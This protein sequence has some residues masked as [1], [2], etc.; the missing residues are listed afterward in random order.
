MNKQT[1]VMPGVARIVL[2]ASLLTL[3]AC[4]GGGGGEPTAT[5][6]PV[7]TP[8]PAITGVAAKGLLV[9]ATVEL[10][11][12]NQFGFTDDST[13]LATTETD[14]NGQFTLQQRPIAGP[15]LVITRGGTYI[16]ES[17][18]EPNPA[19]KRQITLSL[20]QGFEAVL[21]AGQNSLAVTPFSQMV[22][23]RARVENGE[24]NRFDDFLTA[25][26]TRAIEVFG[27][28]PV[29]NLP[30]DPI[31]P[32]STASAASREYAM[33]LGGFA[34][35]VNATAITLGLQPNFPVIDALLLDLADGRFDTQN[36]G[37]QISVDTPAGPQNLPQFDFN[38]QIERFRNN[39]F[40]QYQNTTLVT[41]DE[42]ALADDIIPPE[43]D[44]RAPVASNDALTI[45]ED[46]SAFVN[47]LNGDVDPDGDT[48]TVI[49]V[50]QPNQGGTTAV[51]TDNFVAYVPAPNFFGTETFTYTISDGNGET[52]TGL[53][54]ITVNSVNDLPVAVPDA[55]Q[56]QEDV[57]LIVDTSE[58]VL[59]NDTDVDDEALQAVQGQL[60][61]P[62]G[63][64]TLASDGGFTFTPTQDFTG[65]AVFNYSAFDGEDP[66]ATTSITI[67]VIGE[68]DD[69]VALDDSFQN[70]QED[71]SE[72][73][74][75]V[76]ANDSD[77]DSS[78]ASL[79][80]AAVNDYAGDGT[81]ALAENG[82][83]LLYTPAENFNGTET[84]TYT[85][86]DGDGGQDTATVT[87]QV[88]PVNDPPTANDDLFNGEFATEEGGALN[89]DAPGVLGNDSDIDGDIITVDT[90]PVS[91]PSNG[92]LTLNADGSFSYAHDG[93]ETAQ[94]S[95]VYRILDRNQG[96]AEATVT[97][98][99]DPVN[100]APVIVIND[101]L[102]VDEGDSGFITGFNSG[103]L[104][105]EDDDHDSTELTYTL[106]SVPSDGT[107]TLLGN[108]LEVNGSFT[109]EDLDE[110]GIE[111]QHNGA[112]SSFDFFEFQVVDAEG[113]PATPDLRSPGNQTKTGNSQQATS[114]QFGF[115]HFFDINI[116]PVEDPPVVSVNNGIDVPN[117]SSSVLTTTDLSASD[118]DSS[119]DQIIFTV[120]S[121]SACGDFIVNLSPV[122]SFTQADIVAGNVELL[123]TSCAD[124][125]VEPAQLEVKNA[126]ETPTAFS[127]D[128][129]V[130]GPTI[131]TVDPVQ[132]AAAAPARANLQITASDNLNFGTVTSTSVVIRGS[133]SGAEFTRNLPTGTGNVIQSQIAD[134]LAEQFPNELINVT[135]TDSILDE[136]GGA[137]APFVYNFRTAASGTGVGTYTE[138]SEASFVFE[139]TLAIAAADM[140]GDGDVDIVTSHPDS[141][142]GEHFH[143]DLND[144]SGN[145]SPLS[146]I[147]GLFPALHLADLDLDGDIDVVLLEDVE[148]ARSLVF[149][150]NDGS[151]NLSEVPA[152]AIDVDDATT[153]F[154]LGDLDGNGAPD[155]LT[156]INGQELRSQVFL[157]VTPGSIGFQS[158]PV[159]NGPSTGTTTLVPSVQIA[160][161]D[162]DGDLDG[163]VQVDSGG[164]FIEVLRN[165]GTGQL[166]AEIGPSVFGS[167]LDVADF[168]GDD[169]V[170]LL[171]AGGGSDAGFIFFGGGDGTF[172]NGFS[173][174]GVSVAGMESVVGDIDADGD[175]DVLTVFPD[176]SGSPRGD[177]TYLNDGSGNFTF[178]SVINGDRSGINAVLIDADG[179]RDLDIYV[180]NQANP[181]QSTPRDRVFLNNNAP[182]AVDDG[183]FTI[184]EDSTSNEV[185]LVSNDT[186]PDGDALQI[187]QVAGEESGATV[188]IV[189]GGQSINYAPP[190]NFDASDTLTYTI[191]DGNGGT[192]TANVIFNVTPSNDRPTGANQTFDVDENT[193]NGTVVGTFV[194]D[195][196]DGDTLQY[197]I[198]A[199][200]NPGGAFAIDDPTSGV[201]TV[202]NQSELDFE[203][204]PQFQLTVEVSDGSLSTTAVAV[205]NINDVNEPPSA[206]GGNI[207]TTDEDTPDS[208]GAGSV[209]VNDEDED[210]DLT[211]IVSVEGNT[212]NVGVQ[213]TL[214]SGALLTV[215]ADG[216]YSYDPNG[217][218]ES[219]GD[220]DIVQDTF[221]YTISDGEFTS[222]S[223]A[224][225]TVTGV[226]D[227]P[228]DP[229][230]NTFAVDYLAESPISNSELTTD[231]VD[232]STAA[233]I[234]YRIIDA[235]AAGTLR[236][237]A[238]PPGTTLGAAGT[239]SQADIDNLEVVYENT[240]RPASNEQD[241][242][243]FE[244]TNT[245][246][247]EAPSGPFTFVIDVTPPANQ[248]PSV[249]V[250]QRRAE[251]DNT[252][253]I[254]NIFID[255]ADAASPYANTDYSVTLEL[256]R[257]TVPTQFPGDIFVNDSN[258]NLTVT[259]NTTD[260]VTVS[261]PL[262]DIQQVFASGIF[263][264]PAPTTTLGYNL[265]VTID[266]QDPRDS[267]SGPGSAALQTSSTG[268]IN[269]AV[270][271]Q[272][273]PNAAVFG[274][275]NTGES[276][277]SEA[278]GIGD[279]NGDGFDDIAIVTSLAG[280]TTVAIYFGGE[281][282]FDPTSTSNEVVS[283]DLGSQVELAHA[284]FNRDGFADL[285][286]GDPEFDLPGIGE[287]PGI[288]DGGRVVLL[289]G[290]ATN[291]GSIDIS[292]VDSV[293]G[294][295]EIIPGPGF[296][297]GDRFGAQVAAGFFDDDGFPDIAV[298]I[299]GAENFEV[300]LAN[301]GAVVIF[302]ANETVGDPDADKPDNDKS[303]SFIFG[304]NSSDQLGNVL[305]MGDVNRDGYDDLLLGAPNASRN[306]ASQNGLAVVVHGRPNDDRLPDF[307]GVTDAIAGDQG[308]E[309][310]GETGSG[311]LGASID[312]IGD[313]DGDRIGD[314]IVGEPGFT[315]ASPN[316][317]GL[318][319]IVFGLFPGVT[320]NTAP[321]DFSTTG[322]G[323][324][325][326]GDFN[327]GLGF[328]DTVSGV[329]D[330]NGDGL[331][332]VI[333]GHPRFEFDDG[334]GPLFDGRAYLIYGVSRSVNLFGSS[335]FNNVLGA[336][337]GTV[338]ELKGQQ[339]PSQDRRLGATVA[340]SGDFDGDGFDDLLVAAP[341]EPSTQGAG[342]NGLVF[343][344]RG[345]DYTVEVTEQGFFGDDILTGV[346][347]QNI[348]VGGIGNDVIGGF[349]I[350]DVLLGGSGDDL[351]SFSANV[352][353]IDGDTG[354]DGLS[355]PDA[356]TIV[357]S[358]TAMSTSFTRNTGYQLSLR[359]IEY[360]V[361]GA[362]SDLEV[363]GLS[364]RGI[365][366][367]DNVIRIDSDGTGPDSNNL[368][369]TDAWLLG[370][371]QTI[372]VDGSDRLYQ[373]YTNRGVRMLVDVDIN[374]EQIPL[375][376]NARLVSIVDQDQFFGQNDADSTRPAISGNGQFAV[377]DSASTVPDDFGTAPSAQAPQPTNVYRK[378]L[379][380]GAL[381][382][383]STD[384]GGGTGNGDS[385]HACVSHSGNLVAFRTAATNLPTI[386]P[387]DPQE[388]IDLDP[389]ADGNGEAQLVLADLNAGTLEVV[390]STDGETFIPFDSVGSDCVFSADDG[391]LFFLGQSNNFQAPSSNDLHVWRRSLV[392]RGQ[393]PVPVS[394]DVDN[395]FSYCDSD[396]VT[397]FG[398]AGIAPSAD[399][400]LVAFAA[401]ADLPNGT[402]SNPLSAGS[403]YDI[404]L[405]DM[406][407]DSF[408]VPANG[409]AGTT[410]GR[411]SLSGDGN[412]LVF[413]S[414]GDFL[415]DNTGTSDVNIY[416]LER[417][418]G[419][420]TRV[421][422]P[423][424]GSAFGNSGNGSS[425]QDADGRGDP[426]ISTNGRTI[427]FT[428]SE[429][430]DG[431][432]APIGGVFVYL[433]QV[434]AN[435]P[436]SN[437]G[438]P[439][440]PFRAFRNTDGQ[441]FSVDGSSPA[442]AAFASIDF[443]G[444]GIVF[445]DIA[446]NIVSNDEN[447]VVDVFAFENP[448]FE[449]DLVADLDGDS[450]PDAAEIAS[451]NTNPA[452][453]DTD[454]DNLS[455]GVE[456]GF[457][458]DVA[459]YT[460]GTDTDPTNSDTDGDDVG[461]GL[462]FELT[463]SELSSVDGN[464]VVQTI[465]FVTENAVGG[466]T[467]ATYEDA[468]T[469]D[470][471]YAI[472]DNGVAGNPV[473][474]MIQSG[475]HQSI[476]GLTMTS[477]ANRAYV[478]GVGPGVPYPVEPFA[479]F[480]T[481]DLQ[482]PARGVAIDSSSN[483]TIRNLTLGN[484]SVENGSGGG[485][486]VDNLSTSIVLQSVFIQG[487][488]ATKSSV[489]AGVVG[490]G[491]LAVLASSNVL[492]LDSEVRF[493]SVAESSGST[494]Y[495][496]G[497]LVSGNGSRIILV[498]S[499][500]VGN[501]L[502]ADSGEGLRLGAGLAVINNAQAILDDSGVRDHFFSADEGGGVYVSSSN[503]TLDGSDVSNNQIDGTTGAGMALV[504]VGTVNINASK[505]SNNSIVGLTDN[506]LRGGGIAVIASGTVN[507][508]DSRIVGN[509]LFGSG[510]LP[511]VRGGGIYTGTANAI[512]LNVSNSVIADNV[513]SSDVNSGAGGGIYTTAA[514]D[515]SITDSTI[516]SNAAAVSGGGLWINDG[517]GI[518]SHRIVNNLFTGN[519]AEN[520]AGAWGFY[521]NTSGSAA[522]IQNNTFAYNQSTVVE[523][524][525]GDGGGGLNITPA[526]DGSQ[527]RILDNILVANDD[528]DIVNA[529]PEQ[530][531]VGPVATGLGVEIEFNLV[532]SQAIGDGAFDTTLDPLWL[533]GFYLDQSSNPLVGLGGTGAGLG[534]DTTRT[535]A[536][537]GHSG[538]SP[539]SLTLNATTSVAGTADGGTNQN[540]DNLDIGF[541]ALSAS[542]G[543]VSNVAVVEPAN[544]TL[545]CNN[546]ELVLRE[547]GGG[548]FLIPVTIAG[549]SA[550]NE[551][552]PNLIFGVRP[553]SFSGGTPTLQSRTT[554][555]PLGSTDSVLPLHGG[556]DDHAV[557]F[558][559]DNTNLS[560]GETIG[561]TF[562][563]LTSGATENVV[564]D[565]AC[566]S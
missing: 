217:A 254:T 419:V 486:L 36:F 12:L 338:V 123:D 81:I 397:T 344:N 351:I 124:G 460:P 84:F 233:D 560:D 71:T 239:F 295:L 468:L 184:A 386:N 50:S 111:Y 187:T 463:G 211:S 21:P 404:V 11:T 236:L 104:L 142:F 86:S 15:L 504:S 492:M 197:S 402:D 166:T 432:L 355:L 445:A 543:T 224:F 17:D 353:R 171:I 75:D 393:N 218:F 438:L 202:G 359:D 296:D 347:A 90:T 260:A 200:T 383:L 242:F 189:G 454:G 514:G 251:V 529:D 57:P 125:D 248:A 303:P 24:S 534:G 466:G 325:F 431:Q 563:E 441:V 134:S 190:P 112:E 63:T 44:N 110:A 135:L 226:D 555:D 443:T 7:V 154:A 327:I 115:S 46:E 54:T 556:R 186:D 26:R 398:C 76:L 427:V 448:L 61:S 102:T 32:S 489:E 354:F 126:G 51:Q 425:S 66:S 161:I 406:T 235:P 94:D 389:Q 287:M 19:L 395:D 2:S 144:G 225:E 317:T 27:F 215:N 117:N 408:E 439:G 20:D 293:P 120:V 275:Q 259:G 421:N 152:A 506:N 22:L 346:A 334:Q 339:A 536:D 105:T 311:F 414:D 212:S 372:N 562:V 145:F 541:H 559:L 274:A 453:I 440:A 433:K 267:G 522:L 540:Q 437:G 34:N 100:D 121:Q 138:L 194:A 204:T 312:F 322:N 93:S 357:L 297:N 530:D 163:L 69:P 546:A 280:E 493:N 511:S 180:A 326:E 467:G 273:A 363:D 132:N 561:L 130:N 318:A 285:I 512:R 31:A 52:A 198:V 222:S 5:A 185:N 428:S 159:V 332:D 30:A 501:D 99:I 74:L 107:L 451:L 394:Y 509:T 191:E 548:S 286:I 174:F 523:M 374:R 268:E 82:T 131:V 261:G 85:V 330:F 382:I 253:I 59:I 41:I 10:F 449:E 390:S 309:F 305:A 216:S 510:S 229:T 269:V 348:V 183:P 329:G 526:G 484:G 352:L 505:I 288:T 488:Q 473:I 162:N 524:G 479:T 283:G 342:G 205:I 179:D 435:L 6:D 358:A 219:L 474:F 410:S 234:V 533:D 263:V 377:F 399:G 436:T 108:V 462:E 336:P 384:G 478:G 503:L 177:V 310:V 333:I 157:N 500:V 220:S 376:T 356:T 240:A 392:N 415:F 170:D 328:G 518:V 230:I 319:H 266:D 499:Q 98:V 169:I 58:G 13:P 68:N 373:A 175:L 458:G 430:L 422:A 45:N 33:A 418:S 379:S 477:A 487:N 148:G 446:N 314:W 565:Y 308:Y 4:G 165:D 335:S 249:F 262:L 417:S 40:S 282:V 23:E 291:Q 258:P 173:Q 520:G 304:D 307:G 55:Y 42:I 228:N 37:S 119:D 400:N 521:N 25:T 502:V 553:F 528:A 178:G 72:N 164:E 362:G 321:S 257:P 14:A 49:A 241:S 97:L 147:D 371:Q 65:D 491:G 494:I 227:A 545:D 109:Q 67:G 442:Q 207:G 465:Y 137:L 496:G 469:I 158:K 367:S 364:L 538:L 515:V 320:P 378:D 141:G 172:N 470:E 532:A 247:D 113:A 116:N 537:L 337:A 471:A 201:I 88:Q 483:I 507:V 133:Q 155:I 206:F 455:D 182:T 101:G 8:P 550:A 151:A 243:T 192:A 39:N 129:R 369:A 316:G 199:N 289:F 127:F 237:G 323:Y 62:G 366:G 519:V 527:V 214:A 43:P 551:S 3:A 452:N 368:V 80:I 564:F 106:L 539:N 380:T 481:Q 95:F 272:P 188:T 475:F 223:T 91:G 277:G 78:Q 9:G 434:P 413:E 391:F 118:P 396:G 385:A 195:D 53:V 210:G 542:V 60:S 231:D 114:G 340:P 485:I 270:L 35:M 472:S 341:D 447:G 70:I 547:N 482:S 209:G 244:L 370:G 544:L 47:V 405:R 153:E 324:T 140:D 232:T 279:R 424:N 429:T 301:Q 459:T 361:M 456:S 150:Q 271:T 535:A 360:L 156:A 566:G 461:D 221:E 403:G 168:N 96:D 181:A 87:L 48:L 508:T 513:A 246:S 160:D 517:G 490:G 315:Q 343:V 79:I 306:N 388:T 276:F 176:D 28:D 294:K 549:L 193:P 409:A 350:G 38:Q 497:V 213:I 29:G 238:Q 264:T 302:Y 256:S 122:S 349:G 298:G 83:A 139:P 516:A 420:F 444:E 250:P 89:I 554:L 265:Q 381:Q 278:V 450:V 1:L 457:D 284:D 208:G 290:Q 423:E 345:A 167:D 16:D 103:N 531:Y 557:N 56:T 281:A 255:D 196:V 299:P 464:T 480:V 300:P 476:T 495:G 292:G 313:F 387:A 203:T 411:P 552:N 143:P 416:L 498:S 73:L 252:A 128:V 149:Y 92:S 146:N 558:Y 426:R 245:G 412:L 365:T 64:L 331:D 401:N 525:E 18:P 77:V 375:A 407:A 136:N